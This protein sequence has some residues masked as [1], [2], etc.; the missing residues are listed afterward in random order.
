MDWPQ[1]TSYIVNLVYSQHT[2]YHILGTAK[3][4]LDMLTKMMALEL[5]P[6]KVNIIFSN[7]IC[8][9]FRNDKMDEM[10]CFRFE[11]MPSTQLWSWPLWGVM[12]G[13]IPP[14]QVHCWAEYLLGDL[15]VWNMPVT[16]IIKPNI[17][18]SKYSDKTAS[19]QIQLGS[20]WE[21]CLRF[22]SKNSIWMTS[23]CP[24]FRLHF[25][26]ATL[27]HFLHN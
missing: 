2:F 19:L 17:D 21:K 15:Q 11:W 16:R 14:K 1:V 9:N 13:Q 23:I 26:M 3:A 20:P 6:H 4:S 5:G 10:L 25:Q 18:L 12:L 7:L 24:E 8:Q 22:K 27:L